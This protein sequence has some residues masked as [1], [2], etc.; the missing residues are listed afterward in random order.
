ME[1]DKRMSIALITQLI[2]DAATNLAYNA[3]DMT[4]KIS[5]VY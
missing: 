5:N 4:V 1:E 2:F 3:V